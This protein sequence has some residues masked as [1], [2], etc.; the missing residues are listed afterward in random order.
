MVT[1]SPAGTAGSPAIP[2]RRR[3]WVRILMCLLL[4]GVAVW[5]GNDVAHHLP[6]LENWIAS[7]GAWG[8]VVFVAAVVICT[9]LYIP[10]TLFAVSAGILFGIFKG[11][12]IMTVAA[13]LTALLNF[14]VSRRFL[15]THVSRWLA[16]N[17]RLASIERAVRNEG[18][19]FLFLLRL[20]PLHPVTVSYLL[21]ATKTRAGTF[22]LASLGLI[23]G[24]FVSV[25]FGYAAKQVAKASGQVGEHSPAH[26]AVTIGGLIACIAVLVYVTRLARQ[27]LQNPPAEA[28]AAPVP[29]S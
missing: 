25:Y 15:H 24:L 12:A 3:F 9:S 16:S 20:T 22:L 23:P 26:T 6:E 10:D 29:G 5:I 7:H 17:P 14:S 11:T 2:G 27:A 4:L 28:P 1:D 18:F 8:W 13:L 21:G 19:R